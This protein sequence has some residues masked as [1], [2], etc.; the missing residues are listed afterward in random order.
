MVERDTSSADHGGN[1][2][3]SSVGKAMKT[4]FSV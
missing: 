4:S 2:R 1:Y 3:D